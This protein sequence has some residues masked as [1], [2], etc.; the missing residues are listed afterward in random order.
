[1]KKEG[2]NEKSKATYVNQVCITDHC[3][4]KLGDALRN[5]I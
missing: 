2:Q 5:L 4:L 3:F 1:M